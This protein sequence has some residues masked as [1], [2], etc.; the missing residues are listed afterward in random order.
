MEE[1]KNELQNNKDEHKIFM[2]KL[3]ELNEGQ[4]EIKVTLASL[5]EALAEKFD[6]R[7]ASK[8]TEES[9]NRVTW[10]VITAVLIALIALVIKQ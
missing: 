2:K 1:V 3:D 5:P 9:V 4:N 8:K 6:Q 7:Y 10:I